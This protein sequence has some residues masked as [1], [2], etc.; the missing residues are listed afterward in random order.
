MN[1]RINAAIF[2]WCLLLVAFALCKEEPIRYKPYECKYKILSTDTMSD[3]LVYIPQ[4]LD[5]Q[6]DF[7]DH[8]VLL[9]HEYMKIKVVI[10]IDTFN[11]YVK[12]NDM[13][14][15]CMSSAFVLKDTHKCFPYDKA[16]A[17]INRYNAMNKIMEESDSI[18]HEQY[19][20]LNAALK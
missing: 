9:P 12:S 8:E 11:S 17:V 4:W 18:Y 3:T 15:I 20:R 19:Q 10:N 16:M 5:G 14:K 13:P 1:A 2:L 6:Y 7:K